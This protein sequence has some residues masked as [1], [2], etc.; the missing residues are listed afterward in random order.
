M[1]SSHDLSLLAGS[2]VSS[3]L[4]SCVVSFIVQ[5]SSAVPDP[6]ILSVFAYLN[7]VYGCLTN[8]EQEYPD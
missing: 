5:E 7:F 2:S 3:F 8:T 1:I 4:Q 6:M